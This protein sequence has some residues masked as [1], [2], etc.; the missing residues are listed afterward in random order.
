MVMRIGSW[1]ELSFWQLVVRVLSGV[2]P[3]S[4]GLARAKDVIEDQPLT[5][6]MPNGWLL[7]LNGWVFGLVLGILMAGWWL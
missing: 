6:F 1:I 5:R 2:R 4:H 3:L 7:A